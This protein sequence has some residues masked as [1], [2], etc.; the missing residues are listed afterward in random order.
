M[1]YIKTVFLGIVVVAI[2]VYLSFSA[3]ASFYIVSQMDDA[4]NRERQQKEEQCT[5]MQALVN[6]GDMYIVGE[7]EICGVGLRWSG[8]VYGPSLEDFIEVQKEEIERLRK[9]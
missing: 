9:Q 3:V 1:K 6:A 5:M 7:T 2:A 8:K 4:A